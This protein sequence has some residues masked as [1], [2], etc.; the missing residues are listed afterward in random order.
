MARN[1]KLAEFP[2]GADDSA[3]EGDGDEDELDVIVAKNM[4]S[5]KS[6]TTVVWKS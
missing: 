3:P 2:V 4:F 6:F 5:I 1:P